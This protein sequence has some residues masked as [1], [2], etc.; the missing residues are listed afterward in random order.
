MGDH[1]V[2]EYDP[3]KIAQGEQTVRTM[4]AMDRPVEART[5]HDGAGAPPGGRAGTP[6]ATSPAKE[7][8]LDPITQAIGWS[9]V[10]FG[11]G[12]AGLTAASH[13]YETGF[14]VEGVAVGG[15]LLAGVGLTGAAV[16]YSEKALHTP[17]TPEP[18]WEHVGPRYN[19]QTHAF[20]P[21]AQVVE[22]P[23]DGAQ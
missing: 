23:P 12:V 15:L 7:P 3:V 17:P 20:D 16:Y 18:S 2:G 1:V 19:P 13:V 9:G 21:D 14:A 22:P 5:P 11:T 10:A 6:A 4:A 8:T